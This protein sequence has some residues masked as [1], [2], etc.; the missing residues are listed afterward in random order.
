M[1]GPEPT[2]IPHDDVDLFAPWETIEI[3]K[4]FISVFPGGFHIQGSGRES[5]H[6]FNTH[7]HTHYTAISDLLGVSQAATVTLDVSSRKKVPPPTTERRGQEHSTRFRSPNKNTL[8]R[9]YVH[10]NFYRGNQDLR[11]LVLPLL[12]PSLAARGMIYTSLR[13]APQWGVAAAY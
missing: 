10:A 12:A 11:I 1:K 8:Q 3:L 7:T 4:G 13:A 5:K 9:L 2:F 6:T